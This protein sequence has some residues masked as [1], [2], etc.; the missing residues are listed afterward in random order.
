MNQKQ[1]YEPKQNME[2]ICLV[3]KSLY[4]LVD[5]HEEQLSS[6]ENSVGL[7]GTRGCPVN[8]RPDHELSH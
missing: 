3:L 1:K 8:T 2:T 4:S 6:I 7:L 5:F